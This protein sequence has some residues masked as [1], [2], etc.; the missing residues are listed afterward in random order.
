MQGESAD[1]RHS[2]QLFDG[3]FKKRYGN[4][5]V[6]LMTTILITMT[7]IVLDLVLAV[8]IGLFTR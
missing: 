1:M 7:G 3:E 2:L 4:S 5:T 6:W 8:K